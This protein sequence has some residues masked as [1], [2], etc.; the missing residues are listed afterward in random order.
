VQRLKKE[1]CRSLLHQAAASP[2]QQ[3]RKQPR[4]FSP[5]GA[6]PQDFLKGEIQAAAEHSEIIPRSIDH[7]KTQVVSPT[8]VAREP[9]FD[10]STEL[11]EQ[12][13]LAAEMFGLRINS[14]CVRRSL[15]V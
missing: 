2:L 12:F 1:V 15:R 14:E 9:K 13:G 5:E 8:D 6:N 3:P 11:G 4:F 7:A 10:T